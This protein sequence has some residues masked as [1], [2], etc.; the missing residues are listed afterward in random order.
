MKKALSLLCAGFL[1]ISMLSSCISMTSAVSSSTE[2]IGS[3]IGISEQTTYL[4]MFGVGGPRQSIRDAAQNGGI[5]KITHVEHR[6]KMI[7]G[8][9]VIKHKIVVYGE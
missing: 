8:G 6:D 3:K 4:Y 5:T 2:P 1:A 7:L 9:L